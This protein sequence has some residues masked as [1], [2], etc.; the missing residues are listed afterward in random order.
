MYYFI[1]LIFEVLEKTGFV[2]FACLK[3]KLKTA[4]YFWFSRCI[5]RSGLKKKSNFHS[6][7]YTTSYTIPKYFVLGFVKVKCPLP[8]A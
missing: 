8:V 3:E 7:V 4:V 2:F 6:Y 5:I 1:H